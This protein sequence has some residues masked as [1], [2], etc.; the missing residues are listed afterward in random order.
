MV[1][2][3]NDY[4]FISAIEEKERDFLW[5]WKN[6]SGRKKFEINLDVKNPKLFHNIKDNVLVNHPEYNS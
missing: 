4:K 6:S 5:I 2:S 1:Y 3:N